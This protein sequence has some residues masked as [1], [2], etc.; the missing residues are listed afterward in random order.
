MYYPKYFTLSEFIKSETATAFGI[1]N[2]PTFEN[3]NNLARLCELVL[4]PVR[5]QL[6]TPITVTSGYRCPA[7]NRRVGG[8]SNSQHL[9]G[10][11]ADVKA[12]DLSELFEALAE[13]KNVDQLLFEDNSRTRWIHVSIAPLGKRPRN[14]VNR[15]YKA[16]IK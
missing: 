4:D 14:Y 9:Y 2:V 7:L 15:N 5:K 6:G 12:K 11:A 1:S 3:V 13:N 8:V 10:L 16:Y